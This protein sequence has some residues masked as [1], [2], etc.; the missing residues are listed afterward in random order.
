MK[1]RRNTKPS[2]VKNRKKK[3]CTIIFEC[4]VEIDNRMKFGHWDIDTIVG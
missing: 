1:L 4:P 3:L 2:R